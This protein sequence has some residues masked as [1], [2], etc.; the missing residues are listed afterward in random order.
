MVIGARSASG[1]APVGSQKIRVEI[2]TADFRLA[3]FDLLDRAVAESHRR[4]SRRT[5]QRLLRPGV[6]GVNA[7]SIDADL[8]RADAGHRVDH[9][10]TIP[11]INDLPQRLDPL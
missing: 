6:T 3:R 7:I 10:K 5:R 4:E 2:P 1:F 9:Q 11:I 8:M